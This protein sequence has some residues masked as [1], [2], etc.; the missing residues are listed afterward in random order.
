MRTDIRRFPFGLETRAAL[1]ILFSFGFVVLS[2][3]A[4]PSSTY[5][6]SFAFLVP[7]LWLVYFFR[8][9][10]QLLPWHFALFS[11]GLLLHDLG[12]FG[13]YR[14]E[15]LGVEFDTYVHFYFGLAGALIIAHFLRRVH[16]MIGLAWWTTVLLFVLGIGAIHELIEWASTLWLGPERGM[17][18]VNASDPF[19][20]QRDLFNNLLGS[21]LALVIS[22]FTERK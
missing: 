20:T 11:A 14:R 3:L 5:R 8:E 16:G 15:F 9:H 6:Y 17:L 12:V 1:A 10:L 19:D 13:W 18:K 22:H 4:P 2:A 21:L 7:I